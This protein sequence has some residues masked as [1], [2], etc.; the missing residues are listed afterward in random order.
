MRSEG[1]QSMRHGR[2][3]VGRAVSRGR[4]G[5][6]IWYLTKMNCPPIDRG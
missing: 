4:E 6:G 3:V 5:F 1:K 2:K